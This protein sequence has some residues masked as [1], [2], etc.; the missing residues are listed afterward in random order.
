MTI[1]KLDFM[2]QVLYKD[3]INSLEKDHGL[4][5]SRA[6]DTLNSYLFYISS[7]EMESEPKSVYS[8]EETKEDVDDEVQSLEDNTA[9]V[10]H[11]EAGEVSTSRPQEP[12]SQRLGD[13][14]VELHVAGSPQE[15]LQLL[16]S[17]TSHLKRG[18]LIQNSG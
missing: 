2:A 5:P 7:I 14:F 12:P 15:V 13:T 18:F 8:Q 6:L 11:S 4:T 3:N 17:G 9:Q 10:V 16:P 1:R